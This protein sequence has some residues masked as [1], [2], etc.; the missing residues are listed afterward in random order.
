MA[1][2]IILFAGRPNSGKGSL[3]GRLL[4]EYPKLFEL[5]S[6][7]DKLREHRRMRTEIG[8][9]AQSYMA[10]GIMVPDDLIVE[11]VLGDIAESTKV[12]LVDGFPRTIGQFQAMLDAKLYPDAVFLIEISEEEAL[13]RSF[14]RR[15]CPGCGAT[16]T[17][18]GGFNPPK[19]RAGKC[20]KC[21]EELVMREDDKPEVSQKRQNVYTTDTEPAIDSAL[22]LFNGF[23]IDNMDGHG[24]ERVEAAL[25]SI[26]VFDD[27]TE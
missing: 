11:M 10:Q 18:E 25:I 13:T 16:Y 20:D 22:A 9:K 5:Y 6:V 2:S 8:L 12:L 7:G 14:N 3:E 17:I 23:V 26:G 21:G 4:A 27:E 1:K 15:V 24:F 19:K